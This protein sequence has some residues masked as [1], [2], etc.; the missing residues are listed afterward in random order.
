MFIKSIALASVL[1]LG[2]FTA[3]NAA[4][5]GI[6]HESGSSWNSVTH[7]RASEAYNGSS[8]TRSTSVGVNYAG[9]GVGRPNAG[10]GAGSLEVNTSSTRSRESFSGQ[11]SNR[12]TGGS[13]ST[14]SGSSV[15]AN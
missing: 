3:A 2:S 6:R 5:V 10:G 15:F 11:S 8:R 14:F 12:F 4:E 9:G 7:G 1:A 13:S